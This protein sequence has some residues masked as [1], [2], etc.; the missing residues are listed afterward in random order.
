[1]N[2]LSN[3]LEDLLTEQQL[4]EYRSKEYPFNTNFLGQILKEKLKKDPDY[5]VWAPFFYCKSPHRCKDRNTPSIIH[6][7]FTFISNKGRLVRVKKGKWIPIP[8][9]FLAIGYPACKIPISQKEWHNITLHRALGSVFIPL[10]PELKLWHPKD[11][12]INHI[13]GIKS[14]YELSNLEWTTE[15]GNKLHAVETGLI[16][17][18]KQSVLSKPVKGRVE[19]GP[20]TGHEF[21]LYGT[22][23]CKKYSFT[24]P[25]ITGCCKGR[26]RVHK[27]CSWVYAT[28]LE[29][30]QLPRGLPKEIR[31]TLR[32]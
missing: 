25:K 10:P 2:E 16:K 17:S 12:Q 27:N 7:Y 28:E 1:M 15:L 26:Y 23:D 32:N 18:G 13:D 9:H 4:K 29:S 19:E 21:I 5:E 6:S 3:T 11:L 24:Q 22:S 30:I 20:Y 31:I 14:N 8:F